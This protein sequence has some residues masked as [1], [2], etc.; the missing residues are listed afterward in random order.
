MLI[1]VYVYV[2]GNGE[3]IILWISVRVLIAALYTLGREGKGT[4]MKGWE[5]GWGQDLWCVGLTWIP[6]VRLGCWRWYRI[7]KDWV[8]L[9]ERVAKSKWGVLV[10]LT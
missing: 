1:D 7:E 9:C 4:D 3:G 5:L 8:M 10:L 6:V 2:C